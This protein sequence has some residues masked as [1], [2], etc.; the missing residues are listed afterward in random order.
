LLVDAAASAAPK[1]LIAKGSSL[2]IYSSYHDYLLVQY[3]GQKG[4]IKK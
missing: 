1:K 3:D 2:N 4:W